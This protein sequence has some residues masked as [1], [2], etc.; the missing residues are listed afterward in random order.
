MLTPSDMLAAHRMGTFLA[1]AWIALVCS[2]S[3][4][5][6]PITIDTPLSAQTLAWATVA[7][8]TVKSISTLAAAI[9]AAGSATIFT[10]PV[11][12]P[13]A[14]LLGPSSAP[15][16]VAPS[17][18]SISRTSIWPMRPAAPAMAIFIS[19]LAIHRGY[20][21]L[22]PGIRDLRP[23]RRLALGVG[24][25]RDVGVGG[26]G[27]CDVEDLLREPDEAIIEVLRALHDDDA[28]VRRIG[29]DRLEGVGMER[30]GPS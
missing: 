10:P 18:R 26:A 13:T 8:G 24:P 11:S 5:V 14:L 15:A 23:E 20:I 19:A 1:A 27:R 29:A 2:A 16:S 9:A 6:V 12:V 7:A 17:V 21:D 25:A 30:L 28:I 4:P 3:R 22:L